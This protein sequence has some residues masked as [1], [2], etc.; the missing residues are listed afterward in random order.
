[1]KPATLAFAV[2]LAGTGAT[3]A[4]DTPDADGDGLISLDELTAAYPDIT[5]DLF[6]TLDADASGAL[7]ADELAAAKQAGLLP[8]DDM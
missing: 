1:M 3:F 6:V 5:E 7:D 8:M 2:F 4:Q